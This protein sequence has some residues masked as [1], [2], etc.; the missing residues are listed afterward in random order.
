MKWSLFAII[1][2]A[3]GFYFWH[4][5]RPDIIT[6]ESSIATRA[7]GMVDFDFGIKQPTPWEWVNEVPWWMHLSFHDHPPLVFLL[8]H[9]SIRLFGETPFAI[10]LPSVLAGLA[11]ILLVFLIGKRLY[12]PVV[13]LTASTLFAFTVNHVWLSRIG[14]QESIAISLMLA[15]AY[16]FLRGLEQPQ[17]LIWSGIFLSLAFL[18]KYHTLILLP[19]FG[20][21]LALRGWQFIR[22]NIRYFLFSIFFFLLI[23]SPVIIYNTQLYRHFGHFDFQFSQLFGQEVKAWPSRPGQEVLGSYAERI[24]TYIPRLIESNSPYFLILAAI[25]L[26][27]ILF[28]GIRNRRS[29]VIQHSSFIIIFVWLLLFLVFVGPAHRFLSLLTPWLA[30]AAGYAITR[31]NYSQILKNLRIVLIAAAVLA[32]VEATYAY[33]SIIALDPIGPQPWA[34]SYLRRQAHSWGFNQLNEYLDGRLADKAPAVAFP[35]EMRF[36]HELLAGAVRRGEVKGAAFVPQ[37]I[38]YNNNIN[39]S[40]QL[41]IFLRRIIYDGWPITSAE[42]FRHGMADIFREAGITEIY[43]INPTK[44]AL[45]DRAL[46]PTPD[47]DIMEAELKAQGV[48]PT[49]IKNPRGEVAF[50]V[51]QFDLQ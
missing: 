25:G 30:I 13:G 36:V 5:D 29:F 50:R 43:F 4:L 33:N 22:T 48:I 27:A 14:L 46:P 2:L 31:L 39:S 1:L 7:I 12:S 3:A 9:Y 26:A 35:I 21:V 51:Y 24:R 40:S 32:I 28:Q 6:D 8:Q 45:Q 23:A 19:I 42:E 47:G 20:T 38:V 37:A 44:H 18:A 41:W 10:R 15:S 49:E 16:F 17:R 11:T 34:Y